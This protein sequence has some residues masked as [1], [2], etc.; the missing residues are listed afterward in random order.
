MRN[1]WGVRG[2]GS[3]CDD[4]SWNSFKLQFIMIASMRWILACNGMI[5]DFTGIIAIVHFCRV[6]LSSGFWWEGEIVGD[7]TLPFGERRPASPN[8]GRSRHDRLLLAK[9]FKH[10]I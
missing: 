3:A 6:R 7:R 10:D 8:N 9:L 4:Q 1:M 5:F 2:I